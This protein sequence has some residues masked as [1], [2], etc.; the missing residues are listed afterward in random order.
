MK[1]LIS[2]CMICL[3]LMG[4]LP[5]TPVSAAANLSV[6]ASASTVTVGQNVT[7]TLK[8]DG[9]GQT[10]GG[11]IGSLSYDTNVFSYV[12]FSGNDVQVNGGAGK[13]RFVYTPT[14][15]QAP[16][17]AT[18]SFTFKSDA[19]GSCNFTVA[20]E[21]FVN[22]TDYA[23]LGSPSGSV[24]VTASNP[25]LS[26]NANLKSLVPS[27]GTL[28][29]KFDPDVTEYKIT[30]ANSVKSVSLVPTPEH[31]GAKTSISG[32]N[33][34]EV[35]KNTRVITVTAPNGTTKKYTVVITRAAAPSTT[36]STGSGST[37]PT[38]TRPT[39]PP[40]DA[41]DVEV[42]GKTM[43]ILD[44]Q[45]A[46]DL[47]NGFVW[48]N[49]TINDIEVPAAV[50]RDTEMTLLYL[51]AEDKIG[52]GFYIYDA[53]ADAF[54]RY[55]CM[56]VKNNAY[57]LFDLPAEHIAPAGTTEGTLFFDGNYVSAY[58]YEDASL[59]DFYILWAAP[60]KGVAG[61]Y[62]YD[63]KEGSLQ[64]YHA[65]P[66]GEGVVSPTATNKPTRV[67]ATKKTDAKE[68][69]AKGS[70]FSLGSFLVQHRQVWLYAMIGIGAVVVLTFVVILIISLNK[71][72]KGKH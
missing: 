13:M 43:T 7:V 68:A 55:L 45:A 54:T 39:L 6:S 37:T 24:T 14:T 38:G 1:R 50:N 35:G 29:P 69:N 64:R 36:G 49:I 22:D 58:V 15:A 11:V 31:S 53:A 20:T 21:E 62:T 63:K 19:P 57:L 18:V 72:N 34:V 48:S 47:P 66:G 42:G 70:A 9:D 56:S 60:E 28:T 2:I 59:A 40:E 12:S 65:T 4:L 46:V 27:K 61:W 26:G 44:T 41:L 30:V 52:N 10:I 33:A 16:T 71:R 32:K 17:S 8:Y 51:T 25:T 23:S 3:L 67:T 5:T